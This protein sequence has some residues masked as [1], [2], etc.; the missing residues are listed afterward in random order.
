MRVILALAAAILLGALVMPSLAA[1]TPLIPRA[2]FFGNPTK[3]AG[4]IS[5]DG[6]WL[7]YLAPRNGVLNV[8]V[9]PLA[10]PDDA[11]PMTDEHG[12]PVATYFWAPDSS[13]I[14]YATDNGGDENYQLYGVDVATGARKALTNFPKARVSIDAIS[15]AIDDRI[16]ID[17]NNRDPHYF[18]VL[19]LDLKTGALSTAFENDQGFGGFLIDDGL[20]LR[21]A[22][23]PL[24]SGDVA[25]YRIKDGKAEDRP[26][27]TIPYEDASTTQPLFFSYDGKMLYWLDSRG[28]DTT[29]L[30]AENVATGAKSVLGSDPRADIGGVAGSETTGEA[31][32]YAVNYLRTEWRFL[33]PKFEADFKHL[34]AH[35]KGDVI[36]TSRDKADDKWTV[37]TNASDA[38][39]DLWL[40][41]RKTKALT[42]LYT[43]RPE[44]EGKP[45]AP[46]LPV[47]IRSRDGLP[48]VSYLTLPVGTDPRGDGRPAHPLPL[49]LWVHGGPWGRDVWGYSAVHQW[50]A[51]RGY[52]V[53]SVNFRAS[54]GLGKKFT[55]AGDLQWGRKMQDDLL[56]A[57]DW[58][59]ARGVTTKGKVAIA[60]GSYG[61]YATL[62][63]LAFTPD[64]FA[65][66]VDLFGPVNLNTLLKTTPSYWAAQNQIM[67][68]RMG[69]PGT[70]E[71]Q[72]I[73]KERSPLYAAGAIKKPLLIGQ[74]ANDARVKQDES[75]QMVA[76]MQ[77][78]HVPVTYLLFDD[79]G[80]GFQ[81][82]ANNLAFWG[83]AEQFLHQ[84]LGGRAEPI[85][86]VGPGATMRVIA[87]GDLIPGLATLNVKAAAK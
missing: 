75:D 26:F 87:G 40:F 48:L 18:D 77:A 3:A 57:V 62:A 60:G 33:D 15:H 19:S 56:D 23:K 12:R 39:S 6:Q 83:V 21:M 81:R 43:T 54:T 2:D 32:A 8:W 73:L 34:Q 27:E 80:H 55:Q 30:I 44:L 58:A 79:E 28:R 74:G 31:E 72:A 68:R 1:D 24:P 82:P 45:L 49:V 17:V 29:A 66:G 53:L 36:I 78:N 46:M 76:A 51:N 5:P 47:E 41:D 20:N 65:C 59:I 84:C 85:G 9:A 37:A 22:T 42:R 64:A 11:R 10:H 4:R 14:L 69:D 63:G 70:P 52:A 16:L 13:M 71:G 61:G 38:P 35:L 7:S 67:F 25:L 50:L 86:D